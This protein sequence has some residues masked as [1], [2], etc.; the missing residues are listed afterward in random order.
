VDSRDHPSFCPEKDDYQQGLKGLTLYLL[1]VP[2]P[3]IKFHHLSPR[4]I[5]PPYSGQIVIIPCQQV[6]ETWMLGEMDLVD[7]DIPAPISC[8][9]VP[10]SILFAHLPLSATSHARSRGFFSCFSCFSIDFILY[11]LHLAFY[12]SHF[13]APTL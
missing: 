3:D 12:R 10:R 4:E 7:H 1:L 8:S 5:S 9:S 11:F 6:D 13:G 2:G